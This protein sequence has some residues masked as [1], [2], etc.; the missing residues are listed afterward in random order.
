VLTLDR[1]FAKIPQ[2]IVEPIES[3]DAPS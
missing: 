1:N 2:V 3:R